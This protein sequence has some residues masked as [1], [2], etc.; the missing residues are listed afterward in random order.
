[1]FNLRGPQGQNPR[2]TCGPRTT[3]W[4]TLLYCIVF[5]IGSSISAQC[6]ISAVSIH[7]CCSHFKWIVLNPDIRWFGAVFWL[8]SCSWVLHRFMWDSFCI[9]GTEA[10]FFFSRSLHFPLSV[11]KSSIFPCSRLAAHCGVWQ[12]W[13]DST[14]SPPQLLSFGLH[15]L[16]TLGYSHTSLFDF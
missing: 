15:L 6:S 3:V 16:L 10:D 2:T 5:C 14:L 7:F 9:N 8:Y 1:M 11:H 13:P 12:H 4:K